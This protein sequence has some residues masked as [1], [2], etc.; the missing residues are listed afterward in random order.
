MNTQARSAPIRV[1]PRLPLRSVPSVLIRG[2]LLISTLASP[3][4][5]ADPITVDQVLDNVRRA[6]GYDAFTQHPTGIQLQGAG[7]L[8]GSAVTYTLLINADGHYVQT[9]AGPISITSAYDG[10]TAWVRDIA[11]EVRIQE[12]SDRAQSLLTST[13]LSNRWLAKDS[14]LKLTLDEADTTDQTIHLDFTQD[15]LME[16]GGVEIDRSSWLPT[17]WTY[18]AGVS[19][20]TLKFTDTIEFA[21]MK[22][23]KRTESITSSGSSTVTTV[24]SISDQ[25][26]FIRSPYAAPSL[27][28]TDVRFDA[29]VPAKVEIKKSPTGHLL[30]HPLVNGKDLGW[31]IFDTGAGA[32][33]LTTRVF[34]E[35]GLSAIGSVPAVGIGGHIEAQLTRPESL[36]LG[37]LTIDEPLVVVMDLSFLD[38]YMGTPIAG[39][40]GYGLL[41]RSVVEL[42]VDTPALA[43]H[44]PAAFD[45]SKLTWQKLHI[46]ERIPCVEASFEGGSGIFKLDS[47]AGSEFVTFHAPAVEKLKL[48]EGRETKA[49]TMGGV[50]GSVEGR[51]GKLAWF[52][53]GGKRHE[54]INVSFATQPKGAFANPYVTGNLGGGFIKP[55]NLIL[56]YQGGR[57][58]YIER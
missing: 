2:F 51:A 11:G 20:T 6:V 4:L 17:Q 31:F 26:V 30:V 53:I 42:D 40:I 41:A 45:G 37:A 22:F 54:N 15:G 55:F 28:P 46:D 12:L 5:A 33:V 38:Q 16:T 48:L 25:P 35:L 24:D 8:A 3:A 34:N 57:I 36:T 29:S 58:A 9:L 43:I 47:G 27:R 21:G 49:T 7:S 52:E 23:P 44:D 56:D 50:G 19:S 13:I 1:H 14:P 18:A 10:N 32:N 39:L